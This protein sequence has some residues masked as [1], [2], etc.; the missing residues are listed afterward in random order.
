MPRTATEQ[1]LPLP[2]V[3]EI[4]ESPLY[5]DGYWKAALRRR[6]ERRQREHR[7]SQGQGSTK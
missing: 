4:P 3:F 6:W 1:Q 7:K 2:I 5:L